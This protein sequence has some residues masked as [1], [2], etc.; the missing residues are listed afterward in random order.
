MRESVAVVVR[1]MHGFEKKNVLSN[2]HQLDQSFKTN[3]KVDSSKRIV[4][5][6]NN[7]TVTKT[8]LERENKIQRCT[9]RTQINPV[10][11]SAVF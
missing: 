7:E 6:C 4:H 11:M 3:K 10:V 2:T 9:H 8:V 5:G 1:M